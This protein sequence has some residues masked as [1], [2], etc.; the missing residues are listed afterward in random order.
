MSKNVLVIRSANFSVVDIVID[1]IT[2]N[3]DNLNIY[4]LSQES[5]ISGI[6]EKVP[7]ANIYIYPNGKFN[8]K[9]FSKNKDLI[10]RIKKIEYDEVYIPSSYENF[11][12]FQEIKLIVGKIKGKKIVLFNCYGKMSEVSLNFEKLYFDYKLMLPFKLIFSLLITGIIYGVSI[13][14][15][16]IKYHILR[17]KV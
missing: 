16:I 3:N 2:K 4:F 14:Y 17:R 5:G 7:D 6:K 8:Y 9:E 10:S 1:Y 15:H 12:D 11:E 13:S